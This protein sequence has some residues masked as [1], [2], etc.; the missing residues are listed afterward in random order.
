MP[1]FGGPTQTDLLL[2]EA[3]ALQKNAYTQNVS[4]NRI[5]NLLQRVETHRNLKGSRGTMNKMKKLQNRSVKLY[6]LL[7]PN[8]QN[9]YTRRKQQQKNTARQTLQNKA[10]Q[11]TLA[12]QKG[13][14]TPLT[15]EEAAELKRR[16]NILSSWNTSRKGSNASTI[17][18]A[19]S[20]SY[21]SNSR[22]RRNTRRRRNSGL[23]GKSP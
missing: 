6:N 16:G 23:S 12:R 5:M 15:A 8:Q 22:R 13:W 3:N 20:V 17:S 19:S 18:N 11:E 21:N 14:M 2:Q 9:Q 7:T 10:R 1:L 4:A